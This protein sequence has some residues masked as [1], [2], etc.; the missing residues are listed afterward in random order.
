MQC[1]ILAGGLATRMRPLSEAI[2]KLLFPV[3]GYPFAHYQLAWLK[4]QCVTKVIYCIGFRGAEIRAAIGDG[5]HFG[6]DVRYSDEGE[7]LMGTGGA[8]RVAMDRGLLD[9]EFL[10]LYGDSFLPVEIA[11][12]MAAFRASGKDALMTV[13]RN[14]NRWDRSNV[15]FDPPIVALYDKAPNQET[16]ARMAYIDYGLS[17]LT[18]ALVSREIAAGAPTFP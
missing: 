17:V 15:L 3:N 9:S 10:V 2:P 5:S 11:P 7:A 16:R 8:L 6:L 18:R 13:I 1:V 4:E 14:E 12:V